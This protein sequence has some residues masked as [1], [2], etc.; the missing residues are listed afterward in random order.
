[1]PSSI[2]QNETRCSEKLRVLHKVSPASKWWDQSQNPEPEPA[3]LTMTL[4]K[5]S[6]YPHSLS[7]HLIKCALLSTSSLLS[8]HFL[9]AFM[10]ESSLNMAVT[11]WGL[12]T[13]NCLDENYYKCWEPLKSHFTPKSRNPAGLNWDWSMTTTVENGCVQNLILN[14]SGMLWEG[15]N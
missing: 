7:W 4:F 8:C 15:A 13:S 12:K 2:V 9:Q 5:D 1:M 6:A 3:L 14:T 11:K 10:F